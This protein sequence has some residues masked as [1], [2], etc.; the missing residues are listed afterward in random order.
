MTVFNRGKVRLKYL[1]EHGGKF[2]YTAIRHYKMTVKSLDAETLQR[3]QS[4]FV[5]I[6]QATDG[7]VEY[8]IVQPADNELVSISVFE[9]EEGAEAS[10]VAASGWVNANLASLVT[11]PPNVL[12]GEV[13]VS[14]RR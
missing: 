12:A 5:P 1:L 6:L 10:R 8:H 2:M 3:V 13:V 7:F 14:A 9:T 11:G 4:E